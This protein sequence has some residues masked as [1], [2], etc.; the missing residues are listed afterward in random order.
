MTAPQP[1]LE[2][3]DLTVDYRA[4]TGRRRRA[5]RAVDQ[6]SLTLAAGQTLGLVGE[7]GSGKST[8]GNAVLGLTAVTSGQILFRGQDIA[9]ATAARRR[10]LSRHL[11]VVFQDPYSSLNPSRTIGQTLTDPLRAHGGTSRAEAAARV[12]DLLERVGLNA[13]AAGRYPG[14]FSGGQRQRIAIA[15]ALVLEPELIICD[16]PT[17]SLD[18]SVQAQVLN[19]LQDLQDKLN[20]G[21][22]FISHDIGVIRHLSH[23]VAVL[24]HGH[25]VEYGAVDAVADHPAHPYTRT[26]LAATPVAD[27]RHQAARRAARGRLGTR[28]S[29][30]P[31]QHTGCP[32]ASRCPSVMAICASQ[33]PAPRSA[34]AT[35]AACHLYP[36]HT[37]A[38]TP[39]PTTGASAEGRM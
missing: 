10:D 29:T 14:Q 22:L 33:R 6:V 24:L 27:P 4:G 2:L 17:S 36:D 12:G 19:L 8:I 20:V 34:G 37:T 31:D 28:P 9:H 39:A 15:R 25:L 13:D 32:F 38:D 18:L 35:Q 23:N 1:L 3:L 26:L 7:S 16:E 30:T 21:Y 11:Q 5:L